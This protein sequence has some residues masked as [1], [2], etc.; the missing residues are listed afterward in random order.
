MLLVNNGF[1]ASDGNIEVTISKKN[2]WEKFDSQF[3][4]LQWSWHCRTSK[5]C[6]HY[7]LSNYHFK[8]VSS[9][10]SLPP[11][12]IIVNWYKCRTSDQNFKPATEDTRFSFMGNLDSANTGFATGVISLPVDGKWQLQ[13]Y[14]GR[15]AYVSVQSMWPHKVLMCQIRRLNHNEFQRSST[16]LDQQCWKTRQ[17]DNIFAGHWWPRAEL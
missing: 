9:K 15:P 8:V 7:K 16:N 11:P 6:S 4:C 12:P 10:L 14:L 5:L 2:W 3:L 13:I 17:K 1:S